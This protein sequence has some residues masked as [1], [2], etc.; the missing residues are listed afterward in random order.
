[1]D[2]ISNI[3]LLTAEALTGESNEK[4][5]TFNE[6]NLPDNDEVK[7]LELIPPPNGAQGFNEMYG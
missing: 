6:Y 5:P 1:M 2:L 3:G 7:A 4:Y